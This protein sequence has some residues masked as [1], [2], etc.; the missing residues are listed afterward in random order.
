MDSLLGVMVIGGGL[1]L[2]LLLIA[3]GMYNSLIGHRN[4]VE[5]ALGS[6]DTQLKK[7]HDLI[8]NLVDSVRQYMQHERSILEQITSLRTRAMS[9]SPAERMKAEGELG[10][11]LRGLMVQVEN[12][13]DLKASANFLHLQASLNE[14]EEQIS[15]SRRAY[16]ASV[17]DFNN[18]IEMF[19]SS[20]V[21]GMMGLAR[22]PVFEA[23]EAERETPRVGQLFNP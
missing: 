7:R 2:L 4:Q 6:V 19:P 13:P 9:G 5:N 15:A 18:A 8:P 20:M 16:N 21:A 17:T 11:A 14:V 3:V 10:Q 23:S 22:R 1:L 12:Y